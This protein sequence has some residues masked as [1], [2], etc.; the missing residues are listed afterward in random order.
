MSA[1]RRTRTCHSIAC[2]SS[3][4]RSSA[5]SRPI[6][7]DVARRARRDFE[8]LDRDIVGIGI[9]GFGIC[10]NPHTDA[11][12]GRLGAVLD[13]PLFETHAFVASILKIQIGVIDAVAHDAAEDTR[14]AVFIEAG[15]PKDRATRNVECFEASC[16]RR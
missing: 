16:H 7:R 15:G 6:L 1:A 10:Q 5:R 14:D 2:R 3:C 4:F 8:I 9:T 13:Q 11:V 12:G